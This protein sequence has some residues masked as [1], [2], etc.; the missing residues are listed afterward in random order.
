LLAFF[1]STFGADDFYVG[2]TTVGI[3]RTVVL[4]ATVVIAVGVG[5][6]SFNYRNEK[7]LALWRWLMA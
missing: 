3:V 6:F 5:M 1:L 7:R 2:D 4:V